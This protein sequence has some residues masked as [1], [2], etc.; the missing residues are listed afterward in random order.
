MSLVAFPANHRY[1]KM[2]FIDWLEMSTEQTAFN[3]IYMQY[4]KLNAQ[5]DLSQLKGAISYKNSQNNRVEMVKAISA[6][7]YKCPSLNH[8][9][10]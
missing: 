9:K 3:E 10:K 8:L 5:G 6:V 1:V 2:G 4:C 7:L